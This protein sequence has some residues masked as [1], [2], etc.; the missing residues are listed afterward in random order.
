MKR[1]VSG[2]EGT[3][4]RIQIIKSES[5]YWYDNHIGMILDAFDVGDHYFIR[6]TPYNRRTLPLVQ[7][8]FIA[9]LGMIAVGVAGS[10]AVLVEPHEN[11]E[12]LYLLNNEGDGL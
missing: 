7:V 3:D 10:D 1:V 6:D 9:K 4:C 5:F 8:G 12:A 11:D 2:Y